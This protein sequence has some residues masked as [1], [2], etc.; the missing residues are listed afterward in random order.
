MSPAQ[1]Q[2]KLEQIAGGKCRCL[3]SRLA[4]RLT[5]NGDAV[6]Q[7]CYEIESGMGKY[8]NR[9]PRETK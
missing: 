5:A 9:E 8:H 2:R 6:C 3:C 7:V 1:R 4:V